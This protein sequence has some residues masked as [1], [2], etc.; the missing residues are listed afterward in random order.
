MRRAKAIFDEVRAAQAQLGVGEAEESLQRAAVL[1]SEAEEMLRSRHELTSFDRDHLRAAFTYAT[2]TMVLATAESEAPLRSVPRIRELAGEVVALHGRGMETWKVLAAAAEMLA[3]AGDAPGAVWAI[4]KAR[5][6]GDGG[7]Y[8]VQVAGGIQSMYPQV[9]A[10]SPDE[11]S[12]EPPPLPEPR[13][14]SQR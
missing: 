6:L 10:G 13:R 3:R 8:L 9:Y 1:R 14:G 11:P 7:T 4:K 5:Q 2:L 12:A